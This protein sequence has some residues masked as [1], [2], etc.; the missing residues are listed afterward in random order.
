[1]SHVLVTLTEFLV[2]VCL[3]RLAFLRAYYWLTGGLCAIALG[4]VLYLPLVDRTVDP[5]IGDILGM[6]N[7]TDL[8]HIVLTLVAW[9][10]LG[11]IAILALRRRS[12]SPVHLWVRRAMAQHDRARRIVQAAQDNRSAQAAAQWWWRAANLTTLGAVLVMWMLSDLPTTEVDD[13]LE[14]RDT[15]TI[16]LMAMYG[17]WAFCGGVF[18]VTAALAALYDPRSPRRDVWV[19][20]GIGTCGVGYALTAAV[21]LA[22]GGLDLL[23]ARSAAVMQVWA[24]PG[25]TLLSLSGLAGLFAAAHRRCGAR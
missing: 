4:F 23:Q 1:M 3:A 16:V 17:G 19:M 25:L 5:V 12:G 14:L 18:V 11:E 24:I 20:L 22:I 15:G 7:A 21:M 8:G 6:T 9:W 10:F 13:M 2:V